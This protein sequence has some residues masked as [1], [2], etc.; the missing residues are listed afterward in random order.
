MTSLN[1][2]NNQSVSGGGGSNIAYHE[3]AAFTVAANQVGTWQFRWGPDFGKGGTLLVDGVE[4]QS[5][6]TDMWWSGSFG[7]PTQ[8][9]AGMA[10]LDRRHAHRGGLRVRGLLRRPG[11][12]PVPVTRQPDLARHLDDQSERRPPAL[13]QHEPAGDGRGVTEPGQ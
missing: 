7:D 8:Y 5:R 2:L 12:C 11:Q 1:G 6:W 4:L 3:S 13:R 10:N 9:L